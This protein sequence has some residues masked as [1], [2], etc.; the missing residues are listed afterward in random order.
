MRILLVH[1]FYGSGAPSGENQVFI[2]EKGMLEKQGHEVQTFTRQSD[3]I[4]SQGVW[5]ALKGACST[6]WN[7][8]MAHD[9]RSKVDAFKPDVVH[10]H[11]SFP[12]ISPALFHVI[13]NQAKRVLTLHNYRLFC[14]AA[15]PMREGQVCT[16]CLDQESAWPSV[17]HGCYRGSRLAT[18][19]LAV[20]VALHRRLGTWTQQVDAFIALSEFQKGR[21]AAAGLPGDKIH[22]KPNFYPGNPVVMPWLER[23]HAVVFVG[24][25]SQEKG[26]ETLVRAWRAWGESAPELRVVGEGPL[27]EK[28]QSMAVGLPIRF[29]GQLAVAGAQKEIASSRLLVLPSEWFEGFPMVLREAFAFGTPAAVSD[30]GPLP[31]LVRDG[32][33]GTVFPAADAAKLLAIVRAAWSDH[34]KLEQQGRVARCDFERL[35]TED[36]NY[37]LLMKVYGCA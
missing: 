7:P 34:A 22:V 16:E 5:G 19:P 21:M 24:R 28:L 6:P 26:V 20:S 18:L 15:I 37:R 8:W 27:R 17:R 4:R 3:E 29:L 23:D 36:A 30:L 32:E 35:Y 11:N 2:D 33:N 25:L 10:V 31:S 13:G 1:N 12:L 14:P 9:I